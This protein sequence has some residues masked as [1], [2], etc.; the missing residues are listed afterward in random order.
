MSWVATN[1]G[2]ARQIEWI[3]CCECPQDSKS[4]CSALQEYYFGQCAVFLATSSAALA[5]KGASRVLT[6]KA[7]AHWTCAYISSQID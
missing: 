2:G 4:C 6:V 5:F 7:V 3:W 1:F